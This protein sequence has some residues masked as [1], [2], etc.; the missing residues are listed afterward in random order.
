MSPLPI[1]VVSLFTSP[2]ADTVISFEEGIGGSP[3]YNIP[4]A[5]LGEPSRFTGEGVWPGVVSP[6]NA[7]WLADEIVSV[8]TSGSVV[9]SFNEPVVDDAANPWG[10]D[11]IVFGNTGCIDTSYPN[12]VVGGL[13]SDDGGMIEVS[14]DGKQWVEI[15]ST[16]A[17][18]LW[19]TRGYIDSQPYDAVEG[20]KPTD[21]TMPVDP[22]LTLED[23][24]GFDNDALMTLYR[25]SGGGTPIDL[26][27]TGL[28][29][30]S[31][32]RISVEANTKFSVEIDGMADVAPQLVGDVNMNGVVDV[33][34]LLEL[35]AS[36]G[37]LEIGGPLADFN[38]DF[39]V[40]I[41]DLLALVGNWS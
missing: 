5:A 9:L 28:G 2:W 32:V 23:V 6:F 25:T 18:G 37:P 35:I 12:G 1:L 26:A 16:L 8:G 31:F 34:D 27:E 20:T 7:P 38:G 30:I 40:D 29:A 15:T 10:I 22:R 3:G 24:M 13:F 11:L 36:F 17:D 39:V 4:A 41:T 21:F 19:P 33:Q 14:V